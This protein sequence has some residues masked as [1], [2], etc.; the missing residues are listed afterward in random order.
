M[1]PPRCALPGGA[2]LS[3]VLAGRGLSVAPDLSTSTGVPPD[4]VEW[5][6]LR[7]SC[8]SQLDD[9]R[10]PLNSPEGKL[11]PSGTFAGNQA[12][13]KLEFHFGSFRHRPHPL[14]TR[15]SA[16]G[17]PYPPRSALRK[18]WLLKGPSGGAGPGTGF[19][20]G[21]PEDQPPA[22]DGGGAARSGAAISLRGAGCDSAVSRWR[23]GEA[24]P[25]GTLGA[26]SLRLLPVANWPLASFRTKACFVL[27][28]PLKL[29]PDHVH[30]LPAL[31]SCGY[32]TF[33]PTTYDKPLDDMN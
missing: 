1:D 17:H 18:F 26:F 21:T 13:E 3:K 20:L 32:L 14:P 23:R 2:S 24:H 5:G 11:C 9:L 6:T 22:P 29:Q 16:P 25:G 28:A 33:D 12:P 19:R 4:S 30:P 8:A 7:A 10:N 31:L 27:M 15:G